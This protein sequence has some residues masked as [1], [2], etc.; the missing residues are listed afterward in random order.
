MSAWFR[1]LS[2]RITLVTVA[3][4][5][6]AVLVT[7]LISLQLVKASTLADAKAQL[8]A[9]AN[10][11]AKLPATRRD[12]ITVRTQAALGDTQ[13]A[14]VSAAGVVTGNGAVYVGPGL[15]RKVL[16]LGQVSVVERSNRATVVIEGRQTSSGGAVIVI[17]TQASLDQATR[18][19]G[20][21]IL[22]ALAIGVA[23]AIIAGILLGR[24]LA[25]PL[26]KVAATAR[27]MAA[28]ERG[29]PTP[30]HRP[31]EIAAVSDALATLDSALAT[32]EGRQREF[33]LS[34]S[35]E[36]RTPLTA[37]RGYGEAMTDGLVKEA[38]IASV[39]ATLVAETERLDRFVSDLL[40]LARLEA[41]DFVIHPQLIELGGLLAQVRDA[42]QGR[43]S[44]LGVT[45]VVSTALLPVTTDGRRVRQ[46]IDGLVENA[47]RVSPA[48]STVTVSATG[49]NPTVIAVADG[50][51]GLSADD[52]DVAFERGVLHERYQNERPVGT[53]LGLSIA[54][55]LVGRLG[56]TISAANAQVGGAVFTVTLP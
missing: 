50:G 42:W 43:C 16:R 45:M 12:A 6:L 30:V 19:S 52:L 25:R 46:V 39:G 49:T 28:G 27:R 8:V 36:L 35:H 51:P 38:D 10:V 31:A 3:V 40:E 24:W 13:V 11:L 26:V 17:R 1:S 21:R 37:V 29:L 22:L 34:I 53:G 56:G 48:G 33:L 7:G 41:D 4:A 2:G 9:Q 55:R 18:D 32:S 47:L 44:M 23:V 54:A 20:Q 15:A 5:V 14:F